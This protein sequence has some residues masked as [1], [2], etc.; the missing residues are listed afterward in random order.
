ME[1]GIIQI[2]EERGKQITKHGYTPEHDLGYKNKE[3]LL[4]AMAYLRTAIYG[5]EDGV[6]NWPWDTQYFKD[7]GYVACLRKVGVF[8]AAEI[9]RYQF[10]QN[11]NKR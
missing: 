1:T 4:A 8:A 6:G 9:D 7:D 2:V 10:S 3:L 11:E 5:A